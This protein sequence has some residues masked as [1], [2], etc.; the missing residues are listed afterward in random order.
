[1][2]LAFFKVKNEGTEPALLT[3][4]MQDADIDA[5]EAARKVDVTVEVRISP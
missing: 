3:W 1:M 5:E 4:Y 2:S